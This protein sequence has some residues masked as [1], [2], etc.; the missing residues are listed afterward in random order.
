MFND[1]V[2]QFNYNTQSYL[3]SLTQ[4]FQNACLYA[5]NRLSELILPET[6]GEFTC[7]LSSKSYHRLRY[8]ANHTATFYFYF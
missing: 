2:I 1:Y 6:E 4:L 3:P 8:E 7:L 5:T